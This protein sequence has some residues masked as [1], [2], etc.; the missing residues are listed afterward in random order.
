MNNIATN[1]LVDSKLWLGSKTTFNS[2]KEQTKT[3]AG[4]EKETNL[5]S[6]KPAKWCRC[7]PLHWTYVQKAKAFDDM[8]TYIEPFAKQ[9]S[10]WRGSAVAKKKRNVKNINKN[11]GPN[12]NDLWKMSL[13]SWCYYVCVWTWR[14][15]SWHCCLVLLQLNVHRSLIRGWDSF[16]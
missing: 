11:Q 14:C 8:F 3:K 5:Q 15:I 16:Q 9:M 1:V 13:L 4:S 2:T 10:Y 6:P 7:K 12:A